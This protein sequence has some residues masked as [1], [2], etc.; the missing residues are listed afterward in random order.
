MLKAI[1][2]IGLVPALALSPAAALAQTGTSSSYGSYGSGEQ[3]P[4]QALTPRDREWNHDHEAEN[5]AAAGAEWIREHSAAGPVSLV[6]APVIGSAS[7][8]PIR[9]PT[10]R[11]WL[12]NG[13][14]KR[15]REP[16][17]QANGGP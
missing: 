15:P 3:I 12:R 2:L 17:R 10:H 14:R 13:A 4:T 5:E 16:F 6:P 1:A 9:Y 11:H 7:Q 8:E